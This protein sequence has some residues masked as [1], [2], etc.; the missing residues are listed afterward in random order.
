L[1]LNSRPPCG[2]PWIHPDL[3]V[4]NNIDSEFRCAQNWRINSLYQW[5]LRLFWQ[6]ALWLVHWWCDK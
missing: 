4:D 6:S 5:T 1:S 3:N 2:K